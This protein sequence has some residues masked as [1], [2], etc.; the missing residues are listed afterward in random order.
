M[1]AIIKREISA[2]FKSSIGYIYLS[3]FYLFGG[4]YFFINCLSS[5]SSNL[6]YLFYNLFTIV[7]L[8]IPILTMR[9]LSEEKRQKT[10]QAL[11]TAPVSLTAIVIGKY[12]G[13]L[14]MYT[15][16]ISVTLIY[17]VILSF[18]SSISVA[19]ILGNFLGLF[20]LGAA[21]ISVCLFLSSLTENQIVAAISGFAVSIFI[22]MLGTI[23][24][25]IPNP[26]LSNILIAIS[27]SAHYSDFS[28]GIFNLVD[29][30]FF[31]SATALF[32]F[33]T[34]RVLEKRRWS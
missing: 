7:L 8:L 21:F 23:A 24:T 9:L 15:I 16:G 22:I 5:T 30:F 12:L 13:A 1:S 32:I 33:L 2:Y 11:L 14:V 17:A 25:N 20:L 3:I 29:L 31:I 18:F 10:D 34:V 19:V 6:T 4:F 27:F 28:T 26:F